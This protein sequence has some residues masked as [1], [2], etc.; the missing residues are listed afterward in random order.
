MNQ[1]T[2]C[3]LTLTLALAL[4]SLSSCARTRERS[5]YAAFQSKITAQ[6]DSLKASSSEPVLTQSADSLLA[7]QL[8]VQIESYWNGRRDY[9]FY[10][11]DSVFAT[12]NRNEFGH[13]DS[14][15]LSRHIPHGSVT[16]LIH[17]LYRAGFFNLSSQSIA[18]KR[19]SADA[20]RQYTY[21][22]HDAAWWHI[23]VFSNFGQNE[24]RYY[25]PCFDAFHYPDIPELQ[26]LCISTTL[27]SGALSFVD[28]LA[29][30]PKE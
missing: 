27:I 21:Q 13:G 5:N 30:V 20:H 26:D 25:A 24:I 11:N 14:L 8:N 10:A 18:T 22:V 19:K 4:V 6:C 17:R 16:H 3:Y 7:S 2:K 1:T 29:E 23:Q 9:H 28:S 12:F 15:S